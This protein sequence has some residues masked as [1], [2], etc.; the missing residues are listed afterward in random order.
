M[1]AHEQAG[2]IGNM[3]GLD[4]MRKALPQY[5][6]ATFDRHLDALRKGRCPWCLEKLTPVFDA[7][8][9]HVAD[10]CDECKDRFES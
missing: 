2:V 7:R 9:E 10:Q 8:A 1:Q 6:R 4:R 3:F 5:D